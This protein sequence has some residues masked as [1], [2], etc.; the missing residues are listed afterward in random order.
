MVRNILFDTPIDIN[1]SVH[2]QLVTGTNRIILLM[3]SSMPSKM[4]VSSTLNIFG[5]CVTEI[6]T[7]EKKRLCAYFTIVYARVFLLLLPF[8]MSTDI[9]GELAAQTFITGLNVVASLFTIMIATPRTLPKKQEKLNNI[10]MFVMKT[11]VY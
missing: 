10:D 7:P 9:Y 2:P 1:F 8:I 5:T 11:E 4:A 6:V 3:M